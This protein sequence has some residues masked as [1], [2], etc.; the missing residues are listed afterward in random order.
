MSDPGAY[1]TIWETDNFRDHQIL[2][3]GDAKDLT[4]IKA[5]DAPNANDWAASLATGPSTWAVAYTDVDWAG[6]A[7]YIGPNTAFADLTSVEVDG[8]P[9]GKNLSSLKLCAERPADW[10][11]TTAPAKTPSLWRGSILS[12]LGRASVNEKIKDLCKDAVGEIPE[13]GEF[14]GRMISLLW[15]D[16]KPTDE[17]IWGGIQDWVESLVSDLAIAEENT[18]SQDQINGLYNLLTR[19][20]DGAAAGA[21]RIEQDYAYLFNQLIGTNLPFFAG[22]SPPAAAGALDKIVLFGTVAL[23]VLR[24]GYTNCAQIYGDDTLKDANLKW[25]TSYIAQLRQAVGAGIEFA[26]QQRL[27]KVSVV[28]DAATDPYL[29]TYTGYSTNPTTGATDVKFYQDN[30][31]GPTFDALFAPYREILDYWTYFD[32]PAGTPLAQATVQVKMGAWGGNQMTLTGELKDTQGDHECFHFDT[33]NPAEGYKPPAPGA[34]VTDLTLSGVNGLEI[35]FSDKSSQKYGYW[36]VNQ[37]TVSYAGLNG[38]DRAITA[39]FGAWDHGLKS[40]QFRTSFP[41][42]D[43]YDIGA[44]RSGDDG[45]GPFPFTSNGPD[46]ASA[47]L[48]GLFGV[49]NDDPSS[50][51]LHAIGF[52][53]TYSRIQP[54]AGYTGP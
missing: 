44:Y 14:L 12:D 51:A 1:L 39:A 21:G 15:P 5:P 13:V 8:K 42:P 35:G 4:Q 30:Y 7:L 38:A 6:P 32:Q 49:M 50:F 9:F 10:P 22:L 52:Y 23:V 2:F 45:T 33:N 26:K 20:S 17:E 47:V 36:A 46:G 40:L 53:W 25:V 11:G 16:N 18:L 19:L 37:P 28:G 54:F 29:Q 24:V 43:G 27:A 34:Y 41:N 31:A 3:T 48:S